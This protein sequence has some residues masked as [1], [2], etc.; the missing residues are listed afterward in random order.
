PE[1]EGEA[2]VEG[3]GEA[4]VEGEGE[5]LPEGEGEVAAEGEGEVLPEGEGEILPEGEG[6]D[7]EEEACGCCRQDEK[8]QTFKE[9]LDRSLGD[10]LL[11]GLSLLALVAVTGTQ[12]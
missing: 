5:V 6:E 4:P 10:W 2:P 11:I 1:G 3:E 9:M 7:E 8:I 12:K